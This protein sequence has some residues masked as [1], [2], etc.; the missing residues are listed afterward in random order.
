[1]NRIERK[2][3]SIYPIFREMA[4]KKT[5]STMCRTTFPQIV[6]IIDE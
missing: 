2:T 6:R 3:K 5:Y 4:L 1:M